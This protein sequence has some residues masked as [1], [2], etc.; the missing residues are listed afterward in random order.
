M[1]SAT[2]CARIKE[3]I[4][5]KDGL[6][7]GTK[8]SEV[9]LSRAAFGASRGRERNH[10]PLASSSDPSCSASLHANNGFSEAHFRSSRSAFP[11]SLDS[12]SLA[13][14]SASLGTYR[15]SADQVSDHLGAGTLSL[16]NSRR[17]VGCGSLRRTESTSPRFGEQITCRGNMAARQS[18]LRLSWSVISDMRGEDRRI[19]EFVQLTCCCSGRSGLRRRLLQGFAAL[20]PGGTKP[21]RPAIRRSQDWS[22]YSAT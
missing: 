15:S 17:F 1:A 7:M 22:V 16:L 12:L 4:W 20:R 3:S 9:G 18:A 19:G 10:R 8:R 6:E 14:V 13:S 21:L 2:L 11:R 5:E